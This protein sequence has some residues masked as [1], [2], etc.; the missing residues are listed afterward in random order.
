MISTS[1]PNLLSRWYQTWDYWPVDQNGWYAH[2]CYNYRASTDNA[3]YVKGI[4]VGN[5]IN[6]RAGY[7][8]WP[9]ATSTTPYA[10]G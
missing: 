5:T 6:F 2:S 7:R 10:S 1:N 4:N 8:I 3:V 9:S